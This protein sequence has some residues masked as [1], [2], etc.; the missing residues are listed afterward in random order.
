MV[1]STDEHDG[2]IRTGG[3]WVISSGGSDQKVTPCLSL[4]ACPDRLV[5]PYRYLWYWW[6]R[7]LYLWYRG[8]STCGTCTGGTGTS[9]GAIGTGTSTGAPGGTSTS[10][11]GGSSTSRSNQKVAPCLILTNCPDRLVVLVLVLV[12]VELVL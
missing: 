3:Y 9:T 10:D 4:T 1:H 6:Y 7:Y 12:L 11:T 8:T 2:V 5:V